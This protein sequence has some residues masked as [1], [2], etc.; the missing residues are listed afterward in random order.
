MKY[1]DKL[2]D[3]DLKDLCKEIL[4]LEWWTFRRRLTDF[5]VDRKSSDTYEMQGD[6]WD[7]WEGV[8][9]EY[10]IHYYLNDFFVDVGDTE[11]LK[12]DDQATTI[13]RKFMT[14][15]FGQEYA[16]DAKKYDD[17]RRKELEEEKGEFE[18]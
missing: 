13:Y 12:D 15:K 14:E 4:E 10:W 1:L 3:E 5:K 17:L 8:P 7:E 18:Q 9:I 2:T 6:Y 11:W 16:E